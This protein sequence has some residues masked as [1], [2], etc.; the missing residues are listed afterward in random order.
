MAGWNVERIP[1]QKGR[2]AIVTGAT[3]GLGAETALALA[4][5]GASVILASRNAAKGAEVL[6]RIRDTHPLADVTFEI[7]DLASLASV[8]DFGERIAWEHR[9]IDLLVNNAGVMAIP[10][11]LV[12]EDGFEMQLGANY[13]GHFALTLRLLPRLL[14]APAPRVVTVSSLAHRSGRI[15]FDDLQLERSYTPWKAYCQSKLATLMFALELERRARAQGWELMSNAAHPG[16]ARTGLQATGPQMGRDRPSLLQYATRVLGPF[17]SQSAAEGALPTL[18]AA[19]SPEAEGGVMYGPDGF[20][21][22]KGPPHRARILD[23]ALDRDVAARLWEVSE[24]LTGV[25]AEPFRL[26]A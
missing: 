17:L 18:L 25:S 7:L 12:T 9:R 5:A 22:M 23:H 15:H 1:S 3:S 21:E 4:G 2:L 26:A 6:A 14:A 8:Q 16:F 19:T 20:Y 24:Q 11:R 13:L 10:D